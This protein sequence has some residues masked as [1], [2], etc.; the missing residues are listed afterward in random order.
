M[1]LKIES[2]IIDHPD[3]VGDTDYSQFIQN[4]DD[5]RTGYSLDAGDI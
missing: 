3:D 4:M 2:K 1:P 5:F